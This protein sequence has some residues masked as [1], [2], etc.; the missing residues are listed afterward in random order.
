MIDT[1]KKNRLFTIVL[2]TLLLLA[3]ANGL[4][5]AAGL[6]SGETAEALFVAVAPPKTAAAGDAASANIATTRSRFAGV[7]LDRLKGDTV[8]LNLFADTVVTAVGESRQG[9]LA[10]NSFVWRG[11]VAG[12]AGDYVLLRVEDGR[13]SGTVTLFGRYFSI[14]PVEG[15]THVIYELD[16]SVFPEGTIPDA[17][18]VPAGGGQ[19]I[20]TL[21]DENE[22]GGGGA[23][24]DVI[25]LWTPGVTAAYTPRH[26]TSNLAEWANLAI[27]STNW[28]YQNSGVAQ[29]LRLVYASEVSYSEGGGFVTYL[30][31]LS[32]GTLSATA[33]T[34]MD[35][36]KADLVALFV[37]DAASCGIGW[38]PHTT[39]DMVG[40]YTR[41]VAYWNCIYPNFTFAHESGHNMGLYHAHQDGTPDAIIDPRAY[42]Y[43]SPTQSFRTIMAYDCLPGCPR[44]QYHANYENFYEAERM[45]SVTTG[46]EA[47]T[48]TVLDIT[49]PY[50][51]DNNIHLYD[52]VVGDIYK[53]TIFS[54]WDDGNG[55]EFCASDEGAANDVDGDSDITRQCIAGNQVD[56][57][58][59]LQS[60][61][62][63][64]QAE[65]TTGCTLFDV[66][67]NNRYDKA[68]CTTIAGGGES[69]TLYECSDASTAGCGE[70]AVVKSYAAVPYA[71]GA[72]YPDGAWWFGAGEPGPFDSADAQIEIA[73][74]YGDL[75]ISNGDEVYLAFASF[76]DESALTTAI[77]T[78]IGDPGGDAT[79]LPHIAY[80]TASG[81]GRLL[82][83]SDPTNDFL[84]YLPLIT[85]SP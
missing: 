4:R 81:K 18:D 29:R 72:Y 73:L 30:Q 25:I 59:L 24:I 46:Q 40:T 55:N 35:R 36:Y 83:H 38:R 84:V 10:D 52:I 34:L 23:V 27:E 67:Q 68:L 48:Q 57:L 54:E 33:D 22:A 70:A 16:L 12:S 66:N 9:D 28:A 14:A 20:A 75:G 17:L 37:N 43:K 78:T 15:A 45:G 7:R 69:V 42:G 51:S 44:V 13:L 49:A 11:R 61:D 82:N 77:D 32:F 19:P 74:P 60:F 85:R 21:L 2:S 6:Q 47:D 58:F 8:Q 3:L 71:S 31:D 64:P 80:E 79:V 76:S 53:G 56:T 1:Q 63:S 62:D 39:G 50:I 41:N 5:A 26:G 65:A